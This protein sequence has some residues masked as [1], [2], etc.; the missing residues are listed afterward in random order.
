V[1]FA[2][3]GEGVIHYRL[4][5]DPARP[6]LVLANSLGSGLAI[7][8]EV[9]AR[10]SGRL[11]IL[12]YDARG[13]G[14]SFAPPA[15]YRIDDHVA[16]LAGLLDRLGLGPAVVGG[17]SVGGQIALGLAARRPELAR[18]LVLCDTAARIGDADAWNARIAAVEA[19]GCAAIAGTIMERWFTPAFRAARPD[20]V[21]GWRM[22]VERTPAAGY[23]GTSAALRDADL[24]AILAHIAVPTLVLCGSA[25][26]ATPPEL[27]AAT[28]RAIPGARF[29]L[30]EGAGHLPCVDSPEA[31]A[32][33]IQEF[34]EEKGLA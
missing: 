20:E 30:I 22:M 4:D 9:V 26:V 25:D 34:F 24:T 32:G 28:A 13:H 33:A 23:A 15:P 12:R 1:A 7:W 8:D 11:R 18:A 21:E 2:N 16:D 17:I 29:R 31:V 14:L 3:A 10:L 6:L 19:G 27:V 5:G